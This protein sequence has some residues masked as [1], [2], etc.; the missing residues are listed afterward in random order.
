[1]VRFGFI[2]AVCLFAALFAQRAFCARLIFL[3]ADADNVCLGFGVRAAVQLA[4]NCK[5]RVYVLQP[6][7]LVSSLRPQLRHNR[8]Q[9]RCWCRFASTGSMAG[10]VTAGYRLIPHVNQYEG[11]FAEFVDA[12]V[13]GLQ[14][15][16]C[17]GNRSRQSIL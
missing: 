15:L 17:G 6:I 4:Q 13:F 5:G 3:R 10:R 14:I 2:V 9:S 7:R 16:L 8:H 1:M 12:N 11:K